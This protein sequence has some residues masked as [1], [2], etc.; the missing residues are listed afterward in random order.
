MKPRIRTFDTRTTGHGAGYASVLTI[1]ILAALAL[2]GVARES[3]PPSQHGFSLSEE[4]KLN[5]YAQ[6]TVRYFTSHEANN[7]T[8]GFAHTWFGTGIFQVYD[9]DLET[10]REKY[11][12]L[13]RGYGSDVC[14]N[15]VTLRFLALAAAYKMD[16][17]EYL[18]PGNRYAESWG[19]IL[20]GLQTLR[21]LQLSG[22][23]MK[24]Y[25]GH[26][27]RK[28]LT[29]PKFGERDLTAG[30]ITRDYHE[31]PQQDKEYDI[32]SSD[33][34]AL[35]FMNLLVL[36]G[37]ASDPSV[38]IADR[39]EIVQLCQDIRSSIDLVGFVVGGD[40]I[41]HQIKDGTPSAEYWDRRSTDGAIILAALRL[42][43]QIDEAEFETLATSLEKRSVEWGLLGGG[44]LHIELASYHSALFMHGL[45]AIHGM[46]VTAAELPGLSY[47][48]DSTLPVFE[49]QLDFA[50]HNGYWALG[51]QVM[52][53][54]LWGTPLC[55]MNGKQVQFPGNEDGLPPSEENPL[56]RATGPHAWFV[57][58]QRVD[59]LTSE[60]LASLFTMMTSY[61]SEFFHSGSDTELGWEAA[62][63]WLPTDTT[64]AWWASDGQWKY[65]DAGRP[66]EAL[67]AA[68]IVLSIFDALNPNAPLASHNVESE[69]SARI[70]Y[71]LDNGSW[72]E[73][74]PTEAAFRVEPSGDTYADG[75]FHAN[76]FG[77]GGA[78]VAEWVKVSEPVEPGDVLEADPHHSGACRRTSG[79]CSHGIVGVVSTQPGLALNAGRGSADLVPLALVGIVPV[80][81]TNEGGT[82]R[83]GDLL[84]SSSTP[85]HAMRWDGRSL[86]DLVGK[87]LESML[88]ETGTIDALLMSH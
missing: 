85:G 55:E 12:E 22:D 46:P 57:P 82:I 41:V 61:E 18:A 3:P 5:E 35:P 75:T 8:V 17:L 31:D 70:A 72:P 20:L 51:T 59:L 87:A 76:S 29:V 21:A 47:C 66:Y 69:Q 6:A 7:A 23:S 50:D 49:A 52:S 13:T 14:I 30:E 38:A 74:T 37:L 44:T 84:V 79:P 64:Y 32:Q 63:P 28:Y 77:S 54:A 27:H 60:Q 62:I 81:V 1:L 73:T 68:Y 65:T 71:Y 43:G 15:E 39:I 56:A 67:N 4:E 83:R 33:D 24:F 88:G 26:F 34:N 2:A 58:L 48:T 40:R 42:S 80:K 10:W 53:Q 25:Q 78:D 45:R 36:E 11:W 19:Q 9:E 16:W 86:C